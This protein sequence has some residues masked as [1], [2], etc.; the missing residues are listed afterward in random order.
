MF[1]KVL[2]PTFCIQGRPLTALTEPRKWFR[3][4]D[5]SSGA[6][7]RRKSILRCEKKNGRQMRIKERETQENNYKIQKSKN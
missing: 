7:N 4:Y 6:Q 3:N 5:F 1:G 2:E